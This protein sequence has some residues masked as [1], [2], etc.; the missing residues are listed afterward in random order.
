MAQLVKHLP[1][2]QVL[3]PESQDQAPHWVPH[4]VGSVL[5]P[6]PLLP[7]HALYL[8]PLN[9]FVSHLL[10]CNTAELA[11]QFRFLLECVTLELQF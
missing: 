1:L 11:S 7:P 6:L 9:S 2:A 10:S 4:S 3:I 5:V 8:P